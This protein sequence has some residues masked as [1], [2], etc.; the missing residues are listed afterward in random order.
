MEYLNFGTMKK[1]EMNKRVRYIVWVAESKHIKGIT[2]SEFVRL[3]GVSEKRFEKWAHGGKRNFDKPRLLIV[4][5]TL[6]D[7]LQADFDVVANEGIEDY[8]F[9]QHCPP[10]GFWWDAKCFLSYYWGKVKRYWHR[11]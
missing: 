8:D 5:K 6:R 9:D 1:K 10:V 7:F 11:R 4:L 2:K 3:I